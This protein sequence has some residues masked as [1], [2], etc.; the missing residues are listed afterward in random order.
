MGTGWTN[1]VYKLNLL[2]VPVLEA[3]AR[4]IHP[5]TEK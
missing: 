3:K 2:T 1:L 4:S 5:F